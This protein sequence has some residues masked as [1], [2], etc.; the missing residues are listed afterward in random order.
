MFGGMGS[1]SDLVIHPVNGHAV[2]EDQI[3]RV[4]ETLDGLR[5]RVYLASR[6]R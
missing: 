5:E 3:A 2:A 4:N 1:L 6:P